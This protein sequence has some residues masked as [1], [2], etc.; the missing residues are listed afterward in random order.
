VTVVVVT[1]VTV[2]LTT[3]EV[4]IGST[5]QYSGLVVVVVVGVVDPDDMVVVVVIVFEPGSGVV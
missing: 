3:V 5:E 1:P 4:A 2:F